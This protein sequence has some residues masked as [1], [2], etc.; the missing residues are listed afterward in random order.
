MK[1]SI[2]TSVFPQE[3]S[4]GEIA[5]AS[6][7]AGF[8]ALELVIGGPGI[9]SRDATQDPCG[10]LARLVADS[11]LSLSGLAMEATA[12]TH[13]GSNDL[14]ARQRAH[15]E[16]LQALDRAAWLGA[17]TLLITPAVVRGQ[18]TSGPFVRY[19][20]AYARSVDSLSRLRFSA[21]ERGVSIACRADAGFLL[22]PP[23]MRA[24]IDRINSPF[25]GACLTI[26]KQ[27]ATCSADWIL[28]L[29]FRL[30]CLHVTDSGSAD[31]AVV[32][33]ALERV[34]YEGFFTALGTGDPRTLRARL[35]PFQCPGH[36]LD[37]S[38]LR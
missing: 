38:S 25:V 14:A 4:L 22:S 28:T 1:T 6:A 37:R 35:E 33:S 26:G 11:G 21:Q 10:E 8:D 15:D 31:W 13:L 2:S 3:T 19:Q 34:R 36:F 23:E 12:E 32:R 17:G 20:D 7:G 27:A 5:A 9:S 18:N 24:F 30:T 16:T 29:G